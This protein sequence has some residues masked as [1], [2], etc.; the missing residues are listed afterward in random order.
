MFV[1]KQEFD[2]G[3]DITIRGVNKTLYDQFTEQRTKHGVSAGQAFSEII[4]VE[5]HQPW[6]LSGIRQ[7][8]RPMLYGAKPE[9]ISNLEK[10]K[11]SKK[12]LI[13]TGEKTMFLFRGIEDL[14][15]D[16]DVDGVTLVKHVKV[17]SRSKV[18][19]LGN[20]PKLIQLGLIRSRSKYIHP[21]SKDELKDITIRNVSA[22]IYDEFISKA[23]GEGK[24]TGEYFSLILSH[25]IHFDEIRSIMSEFQEKEILIVKNEEK[26]TI[27]KEDLDVMGDRGVIFYNVSDLKFSKDIDQELFLKTI[28][29]IVKCNEVF[30]PIK[31]PKLIV[32]SRVLHC[33]QTN[34][35]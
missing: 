9:I 19:F 33:N 28:L 13:S 14:I 31:I 30:L 8:G 25:I 26:L 35:T 11:I 4:T 15:F 12:D 22:K 18:T 34:I 1:I 21:Q 10:L 29:K 20:V 16:E 3:K 23:K 5:F 27:T 7:H 17:I 24:T 32:L 2:D 6:S